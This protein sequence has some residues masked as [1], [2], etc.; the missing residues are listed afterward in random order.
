MFLIGFLKI[1]LYSVLPIER[2]SQTY[3]LRNTNTS[4]HVITL[5]SHAQVRAVQLKSFFF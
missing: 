5:I 1:E 2:D 3:D 4:L